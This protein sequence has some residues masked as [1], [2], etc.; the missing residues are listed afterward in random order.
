MVEAINEISQAILIDTYYRLRT[1]KNIKT[2]GS[3]QEI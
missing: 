3:Q 2:P 1:G